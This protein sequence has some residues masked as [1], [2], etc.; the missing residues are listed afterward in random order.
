MQSLKDLTLIVSEK[1]AT[2]NCFQTSKLLIISLQHLQKNCTKQDGIQIFWGILVF[3]ATNTT[4]TDNLADVGW[5]LPEGSVH[6]V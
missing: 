2:L 1:K 4:K 5:V 3:K 6:N